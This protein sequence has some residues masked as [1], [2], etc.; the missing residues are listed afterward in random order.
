VVAITPYAIEVDRGNRN[1]Y[2]CGGFR[3]LT[4][5][6]KNRRTENSEQNWRGKKTKIWTEVSN[7]RE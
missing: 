7:R 3:H 4:R 1:Y 6:C 2:N 5:N